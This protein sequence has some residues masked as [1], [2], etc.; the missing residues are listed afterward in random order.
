LWLLGFACLWLPCDDDPPLR[1]GAYLLDVDAASATVGLITGTP[2]VVGLEVMDEAGKV[3]AAVPSG[4]PRRRHALRATGLQPGMRYAYAVAVDGAVAYRGRV[5]TAPDDD[6]TPVRL[7]FLGDSGDQPWWVWLQTSPALHWPAARGWLPDSRPVTRVGAAVAAYE[8]DL[9][10]HLGDVV[11]PYGRNAHYRSGYFRPFA[12]ALAN[13]PCY[14]L[15][16]NHDVVDAG[17]Q[18]ILA[19]LRPPTVAADGGR[20]FSHAFGALRL[21]ALDCNSDYSGARVEAGHPAVAF[22]EAEL[23]SCTEPWVVVATHFPMRSASR[24]KDR[25]ELLLALL[26]LLQRYEVSLYLSGHDHCYQRFGVPGEDV[27]VLVS[28]GGG[29]KNLYEVHPHPHVKVKVSA[30]HWGSI[31]SLGAELEVQ[32]HGLD[33]SLLDSFRL[34]L[35]TGPRLEALQGRS[36]GRAERIGK[37]AR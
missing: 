7:A 3:V 24:Q 5:R 9:M 12:E 17:G 22:L 23:A 33:G 34:Q 26:P 35:P 20:H 10:L 25:A 36:R 37:L 18:Q 4:R 8:P 16:G 21:I 15:L 1:T 27:P 14:A 28:S 2:S 19:N 6:R 29:G 30:F 11:Y 32:S 31:Q 13:A